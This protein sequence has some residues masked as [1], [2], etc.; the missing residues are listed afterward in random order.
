MAEAVEDYK[1]YQAFEGK[2]S[3]IADKLPSDKVGL[4][5]RLDQLYEFLARNSTDAI[6]TAYARARIE[7]VEHVLG[8]IYF[9]GV[10]TR[11]WLSFIIAAGGLLVAALALL[12]SGLR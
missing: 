11:E 10:S 4:E 3:V 7:Q 12:R 5:K 8:R 2:P 9:Q 6:V 1:R